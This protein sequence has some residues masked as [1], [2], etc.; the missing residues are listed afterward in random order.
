MRAPASSPPRPR[1]ALL[2][3]HGAGGSAA[4]FRVQTA[5]VRMALRQEF[6]FV[7]AT[8]PFV[9]DA[10]PGVLPMFQGMGPYYSW[11]QNDDGSSSSND[12]DDSSE[13]SFDQSESSSSS[14]RGPPSLSERIKAINA[15]V[16]KAVTDWHKTNPH[17]PI[18]GL[19]AFSEGALAATLLLWQ[20]AMGRLPWFPRLR[21]AMFVCCYYREEATA[22]MRAESQHNEDKLLIKVPTLH[23]L[24]RQDFALEGSR[25]LAQ[26]HYLPQHADVL[27][28][29]GQHQFPSRR[30]DVEEAVKRF[31]R[32][33]ETAA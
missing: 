19:M 10:G 18:V 15:P 2:C 25:R 31:L 27:E 33:Y 26:T 11:F 29:E 3:V 9:S 24:G 28:F 1:K 13:D 5:K 12:D 14:S 4:I 30:G 16:K 7:F 23:L 17:I 20:Q 8:A 32:I 22:Y 21:I 6:E